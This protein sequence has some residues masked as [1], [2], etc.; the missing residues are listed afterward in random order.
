MNVPKVE[1]GLMVGALALMVSATALCTSAG[2]CSSTPS[3]E[4]VKTGIEVCTGIL[5]SVPFVQDEAKKLG[6]EPTQFA[7]TGCTS[8]I[9]IGQTIE[10]LLRQAQVAKAS[11][12]VREPW[13]SAVPSAVP[14]A[15][16]SVQ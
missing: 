6:I 15:G 8:G 10:Q 16:S 9:L 12:P 1:R 11:C 7:R 5:A 2:C 4:Q 3:P 14:A 13:P